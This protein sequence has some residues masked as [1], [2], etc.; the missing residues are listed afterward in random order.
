MTH[1]VLNGLALK[2]LTND[3]WIKNKWRY[4]HCP[5]RKGRKVTL[6]VICRIT[7]LISLWMSFLLFGWGGLLKLKKLNEKQFFKATFSFSIKFSLQWQKT[8]EKN[9]SV[10]RHFCKHCFVFL[11]SLHIFYNILHETYS[12]VLNRVMW[13]CLRTSSLPLSLRKIESSCKQVQEK[14]VVKQVA[15]SDNT[16]SC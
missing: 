11:E 8:E 5:S 15:V 4:L 9:T 6:A 1:S 14:L 7:S 10:G 12:S 13:T 16:L 2:G 3:Y